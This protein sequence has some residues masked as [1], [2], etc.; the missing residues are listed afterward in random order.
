LLSE[1]LEWRGSDKLQTKRGRA[2]R[3]ANRVVAV[4]TNWVAREQR[5][6]GGAQSFESRCIQNQSGGADCNE[7]RADRVAKL[8]DLTN[9]GA[10]ANE[11][12]AEFAGSLQSEPIGWRVM[13]E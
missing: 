11:T 9:G 10:R 4:R 13:S 5:A 3:R 1:R 2:V 12:F 6:T 7:R 8:E